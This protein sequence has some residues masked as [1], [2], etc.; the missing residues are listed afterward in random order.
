MRTK[1]YHKGERQHR[2]QLPRQRGPKDALWVAQVEQLPHL[3][4]VLRPRRTLQTSEARRILTAVGC[5]KV[6]K[7]CTSSSVQAAA[8]QQAAAQKCTEK[9]HCCRN[10]TAAETRT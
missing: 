1:G 4:E 5:N 6:E 3:P 7:R 9:S 10:L 8:G 2:R